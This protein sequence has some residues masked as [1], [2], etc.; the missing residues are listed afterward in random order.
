M[1]SLA[2][3]FLLSAL[4]AISAVKPVSLPTDSA[5][6]AAIAQVETGDHN[7]AIGARGELSAW[8]MTY[9]TWKLHTPIPFHL[10][11]DNRS[12]AE[13]VALQHL[14]WLRHLL[15]CS[16]LPATPENLAIAWNA[17]V[18]VV[19]TDHVPAST[20]DYAARVVAI[21]EDRR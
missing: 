9:A 16:G 18:A 8:Q 15:E 3:I 10:A 2:S 20:R 12:I 7:T 5:I 6:L 13:S 21:L 4:S 17:G 11:H 1:T 19:G 14:R